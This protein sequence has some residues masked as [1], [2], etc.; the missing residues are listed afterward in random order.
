MIPVL[1]AEQMRAFDRRASEERAVPSSILMENAGRGAAELIWR[2]LVRRGAGRNVVVVCGAGNN[3]GDGFVV[4]RRLLVLGADVATLLA[5]PADKLKGD[6]LLNY[7]ALVGV[8]GTVTELEIAHER[9]AEALERADVAVDALLGTGL[10]REVSPALAAVINELNRASCPK[11]ALDLP[12]GLSA[13]TG[14]PL[15]AAVEADV[16]I[17]FAFP[18]L[19]LCTPQGAHYAG[20]V[21]VCDIGVPGDAGALNAGVQLLEL[22]DIAA[23]LEPRRVTLHKSSAGRVLIVA[24]SPGKLGAALLSARG[25]QRGGAGLVTIVSSP[26]ASDAL[27]QRVLEAM[28]ERV[29]AEHPEELTELCLRA[30]AVVV[31]PGL[32]LDQQGRSLTD[33]AVFGSQATKIVDADAIT[34]FAGRGAELCRASNVVLT[35]HAGELGR[36]LGVS[37]EAVEQDRF[38]AVTRAVEL[39]G[40]VV[41]L[42]GRFSIIGSPSGALRINPT[43]N[44][45][46][47]SGG[48]GDVLSGVIAAQACHLPAFEAAQA[49]VFVH[50]SAADEW[51][52]RHST[53]RGLLSHEIA[54]LVPARLGACL[55]VRRGALPV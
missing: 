38:S 49:G 50:G 53:D 28:T 29:R 27:D 23:L 17:T 19:G 55:A 5:V 26:L 45:A 1:S 22:P 33:A 7:R 30:D 20:R 9:L 47:A 54:D 10:D 52:H 48:S 43:G 41:V 12:S 39:T 36:L 32:G 15:G 37:A 25:A 13:D 35:P 31:G 14:Q 46:M 2:E 16:T 4:A 3:G 18:K 11:I 21:E 34:H 24:G 51:A 8:G 44:P 40:A 42:K 6:A